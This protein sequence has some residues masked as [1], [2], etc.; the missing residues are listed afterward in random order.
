MFA[1]DDSS[2]IDTSSF[3][4]APLSVTDYSQLVPSLDTS[5]LTLSPGVDT[6]QYFAV[7]ATIS[8]GEAEVQNVFNQTPLPSPSATASALTSTPQATAS[9]PAKSQIAPTAVGA[10]T[11]T[12]TNLANL[13]GALAGSAL[14]AS[15]ASSQAY[16]ATQQQIQGLQTTA[17]LQQ[18]QIGL[19]RSLLAASA[20]TG[21]NPLTG[22]PLTS[23]TSSTTGLLLIGAV[24]LGAVLL[25]TQKKPSA[26][27]KV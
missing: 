8:G 26:G 14:G 16:T 22:L 6:T 2:S 1:Q 3:N 4:T 23:T 18:G 10:P 13:I 12:T 20:G 19:Q 17:A 24:V 7:P 25:M 15:A 27:A 5:G 21:I 11:G 9:M